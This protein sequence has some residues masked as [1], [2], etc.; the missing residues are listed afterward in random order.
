MPKEAIQK[1]AETPAEIL[2]F[3][4]EQD[5]LIDYIDDEKL[6]KLG[7]K[8]SH[9]FEVDYESISEWRTD[10]EKVRKLASQITEAKVYPWPD[11]SNVKY[12]LITVA[13]LQ[14]NA[15]AYP[16][17]LNNSNVAL[18]KVVG[19][20]DG[21]PVIENGQPVLDEQNAPQWEVPPGIKRERADRVS[22]HMSY[23]LTEEM[24]EWDDDMDKLLLVL[25]I[26]GCAFKKVRRDETLGRNV[27]ELVLATDLVVNTSTKSLLT[28]PRISHIIPLYPY[29][30]LERINFELFRD[31]E[32]GYLVDLEDDK[33]EEVLEFIEQHVLY[34]LDGDGYPEPYIVTFEREG[35]YVVRIIANFD[36]DD[37]ETDDSGDITKV[38]AGQFFIKYSCFPDSQGGFYDKGFGQLLKPISNSVDSLLNQLIDAGHLSNTGGGFI[39]KGFR[40][41][42]G[43]LRFTPGEWKK[44]DVSGLAMKDSILPLPIREPSNVLF[45]LLGL[46]IDAG[47]EIA[48]IQD[49][50]TGGG[51]KNMPATSVLA[52]IEQ[53]M[54]VYSAIF[55]RIYRSLKGELK[56]LY[57]L[58]REYLDEKAYFNILDDTEAI[59]KSDYEDKSLDIVPAADPNMATDIE[60][61]AKAQILLQ[62][63]EWPE[64]NRA[65]IMV[66]NLRATGFTDAEKFLAPP[67][68][69][70]S[71]EQLHAMAELQL[72]SRELDMK[73]RD[74]Q[75]KRLDWLASALKKVAEADEIGADNILNVT[76][77]VTEMA[78]VT[79]EMKANANDGSGVRGVE[80]QQQ[81]VLGAPGEG[82]PALQGGI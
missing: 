4:A 57:T 64:A 74:S 36:A 30:V 20:D 49:V 46:L 29:E 16:T 40:I 33:D 79:K 59:F 56:L 25:P 75:I 26:D 55:K 27:S 19:N 5:N 11:A 15:R 51:G 69:G 43:A 52:M 65:V 39:A 10:I 37:I 45:M 17:I 62:F 42:S 44:V 80:G 47:K 82:R 41:K 77:L 48:S 21:I 67:P 7:Q 34:D 72:K 71:P 8:C 18:A 14:F 2:A 53:G 61:A 35:G 58:N 68:T 31:K 12:P 54:K 81:M 50:M 28:C 78:L 38:T 73:L 32:E 3:F 63:A 60:K 9:G 22:K 13:A 76:E 1:I 23:Q 66:E 70:P 6:G 24:D